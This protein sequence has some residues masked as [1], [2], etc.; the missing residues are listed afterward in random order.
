MTTLVTRYSELFK[1]CGYDLVEKENGEISLKRITE[2]TSIMKGKEIYE[3]LY[4][5]AQDMEKIV[6]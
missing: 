6:L 2:P 1:K 5:F 4:L 3:E